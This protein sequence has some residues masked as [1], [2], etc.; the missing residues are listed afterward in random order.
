MAEILGVGLT[1]FPG[2]L[3]PDENMAYQLLKVL[4][5]DKVPSRL[6]D[7]QNWP[8]PAK[9]EWGA[10]RGVTAAKRHRQRII[11]GF[12]KIRQRLEEFK[13]DFLLIWGDD[14]YEQFRED[15]IPPFNIFIFDELQS[16]PFLVNHMSN[17]GARNV[18]S[19]PIDKTFKIAGHSQGAGY[20][21]HRLIE[22]N[23]DVSYSYKLREA[24]PLPR[25]FLNPLLYLDYDRSGF[26]IPVVPFHVN[27]YGSTV[28]RSRGL[29]DHLSSRDGV[30]LDPISPSPARCFEIGRATARI[31]QASPWRVAIVASSSWSHAFL[32]PKHSW[33]FPDWDADRQRYE[34]LKAGRYEVYK[35][36][37]VEE[38]DITGQHEFLNWICL[39]GALSELGYKAEYLDY[40]ECYLFNSNKCMGLFSAA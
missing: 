3:G 21:I 26:D 5:T 6:K 40:V 19:E 8:E 17:P 22:Q 27:C 18:W 38:L 4:E 9:M 31:L 2:F 20:L 28:I 39:A 10:D 1:H 12:R 34:D 32:T 13:P 7:P 11:N 35:T 33:L 23:F 36:I 24:Q 25:S 30:K 37:G 15:C 29:L 16:Q 14:Q